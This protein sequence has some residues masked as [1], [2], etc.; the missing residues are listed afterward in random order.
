VTLCVGGFESDGLGRGWER[1][2][3]V[4]GAG[5]VEVD[6]PVVSNDVGVSMMEMLGG[7]LGASG[8]SPMVTEDVG[9][10]MG[11]LL[12]AGD[13]L[14]VSVLMGELAEV[15]VCSGVLAEDSMGEADVVVVMPATD[16]A[17]DL[18]VVKVK[19]KLLAFGRSLLVLIVV[20]LFSVVPAGVGARPVMPISESVLLEVS[21]E[22]G[23]LVAGLAGVGTVAEASGV[24]GDVAGMLDAPGAG[25][26]E[27]ARL[28]VSIGGADGLTAGTFGDALAISRRLPKVMGDVGVLTGVLLGAGGDMGV[29]VFVGRPTEV[30][31]RVGV[32]VEVFVCPAVVVVVV[33][34]LDLV[35]DLLVVEVL[36]TLLVFGAPLLVLKVMDLLLMMPGGAGTPV[37][38]VCA[39]VD[40]DV[41]DV[42]DMPGIEDDEVVG[43]SVSM[44]VGN[45]MVGTFGDV[46]AAARSLPMMMGGV[47]GSTGL[48]LGAGGDLGVLMLVGES[49]EVLGRVGVLAEVSNVAAVLVVVSALDLVGDLLVVEVIGE[50]L[51]FGI[52]LLELMVTGLFSVM[53]GGAGTRLVMS[54]EGGV[55]LEVTAEAGDLVPGLE[56]V[57]TTATALGVAGVEAIGVDLMVSASEGGLTEV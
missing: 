23:D 14:E 29:L 8:G 19:G 43:L 56:G 33:P 12:G 7:F 54:A 41:A 32:L 15:L 30:L 26:A 35:G 10:L 5:G 9:V 47:G 13:A 24:A 45:L 27:V 57:G 48:L 50:L 2:W 16:S 1:S 51:V 36:G 38:E 53:P 18:L 37:A 34:A 21:A 3:E 44:G 11:V 6:R 52:P 40:V 25:G 31:V 55:L 39:V 22:A 49:T 20:G 28:T 46:L 17:G 4:L 42:I